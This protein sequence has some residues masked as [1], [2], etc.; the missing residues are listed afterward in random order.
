MD[1]RFKNV[2]PLRHTAFTLAYLSTAAYSTAT[3]SD[4]TSRSS[5]QSGIA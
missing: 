3:L 2:H 1:Q 5:Y 4:D